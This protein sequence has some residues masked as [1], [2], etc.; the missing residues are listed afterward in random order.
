M[1]HHSPAT[2][3]K[4]VATLDTTTT[5]PPPQHPQQT[6]REGRLSLAIYS[7]QKTR[8]FTANRA[9]TL[10]TVPRT[11]L[12]CRLQGALPKA[13]ANAQKRKLLPTEEQSL[14]QWI[15]DLDRRGFPPQIIDV[16]RMADALLSGRGQD[17]PPPP[18]GK[19]WISRFVNSQSELQTKRNRK[20]H[21]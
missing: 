11:T 15:L 5:M 13:T 18:V 4:L 2:P 10:Y 6:A 8:I 9:A 12:R 19:N 16:R 21:S 1:F 14:V 20:F 17:F 7:I 3:T